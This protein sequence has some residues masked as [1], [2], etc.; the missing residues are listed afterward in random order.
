MQQ[1]ALLPF[2]H[3]LSL[4]PTNAV[5]TA[6][7]SFS[8]ESRIPEYRRNRPRNYISPLAAAMMKA[9]TLRKRIQ[10]LSSILSPLYCSISL[11]LA[12][13]VEENSAIE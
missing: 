5:S 1:G 10:K 9:M 6:I 2:Y 4:E 12:L 7:V 11:I 13:T 3:C 8:M